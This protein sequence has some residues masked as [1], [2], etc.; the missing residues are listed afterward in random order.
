MA[1][2][3]VDRRVSGTPG[4][5]VSRQDIGTP[6]ALVTRR[7]IGASPGV[8]FDRQGRDARISHQIG[9]PSLPRA[10]NSR[11]MF[12]NITTN[13]WTALQLANPNVEI[14]WATAPLVLPPPINVYTSRYVPAFRDPDLTHNLEWL[15]EHHPDW[16][17]YGSDQ[18]TAIQ[19]RPTGGIWEIDI[20][21]DEPRA[22]MLGLM[23]SYIEQGFLS[24]A[25]DNVAITNGVGWVGHYVGSTPKAGPLDVGWAPNTNGGVWT[26]L[27]SGV[28]YEE[29]YKD[30][31]LDYLDYLR[32][33]INSV[34]GALFINGKVFKNQI[35]ATIEMT[36]HSDVWLWEGG[37][38]R[39]TS[40]GVYLHVDG[41]W[42]GL[43]RICR[44]NATRCMLIEN[45]LATHSITSLTNAEIAWCCA[46]FLLVK[47]ERSYMT[48]VGLGD[49]SGYHFDYPASITGL[50][51]GSPISDPAHVLNAWVRN[52]ENGSVVVN[53]LSNDTASYTV[54]AGTWAD[55]F[56]NA[57][58]PGANTLQPASGIVIVNQGT[59]GDCEPFALTPS[60][61]S[62]T[63]GGVLFDGASDYYVR[64]TDLTDAEDQYG[65]TFSCWVKF[66]GAGGDGLNQT[67]FRNNSGSLAIT[68]RTDNK[69]SFFFRD[70]AA[71]VSFTKVTTATFVAGGGWHHILCSWNTNAAAGHKVCQIYIDDV[72]A[73]VSTTDAGAAFLVNSSDASWAYGGSTSGGNKLF[74][75][76]AELWYLEGTYTDLSVTTN[77]R[78]FVTAAVEAEDMGVNGED[79]VGSSPSIYVH[80]PVNIFGSN[81]GTGGTFAKHGAPTDTAGP[82]HV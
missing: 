75:A 59:F 6:A 18:V 13:Q 53:P 51:I 60:G 68:K 21:S 62:T 57:V 44:D 65:G 63:F 46:N 9:V 16:L 70:E 32:T 76:L 66:V 81:Y 12:G 71:A 3:A 72:A 48:I 2:V 58:T 47:E 74:G 40:G 64:S 42:E 69:L 10:D 4:L 55:Q 38:T 26:P 39:A 20:T 50:E 36:G 67:I 41:L 77:R 19:S 17:I 54:P 49:G 7:T 15:Q 33:A 24:I 37:H 14:V 23:L 31:V 43:Y 56:G 8:A 11:I 30:A 5:V 28:Q 34:G 82:S 45:E 1:S 73:A 79:A 29:I 80:G 25:L 78:G 35:D 22:Y 27:F 52:Y 61:S